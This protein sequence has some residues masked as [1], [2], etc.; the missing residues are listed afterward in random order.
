MVRGRQHPL[1]DFIAYY[2]PLFFVW[3]TYIAWEIRS[4]ILIITTSRLH[5][6]SE[7][8]M[9]R[10]LYVLICWGI[11]ALWI[12]CAF[13][14]IRSLR[15]KKVTGGRGYSSDSKAYNR[16]YSWLVNFFSSADPHKL[17]TSK[18]PKG[19]KWQDV[20][21][22]VMGKTKDNRLVFIPSDCE[23]NLCT[24]GAPGSGKTRGHAIVNAITFA[25]SV[26]AVD[27]K[28]D[29][30][31]YV[32][33]HSFRRI[34]R[35]CPDA[36]DALTESVHFDPLAGY[37]D[38]SPTD[39]KIFMANM[40]IIIIPDE[41]GE[42]G[43]YFTGRARKMLRAISTYMLW[44]APDTGFSDIVH[45]ILQGNIFDWA[46]EISK[47]DCLPAKELI[48]S[49]MDGNEKNAG[50]AYDTLTSALDWYSND[51]LDVLLSNKHGKCISVADLE[52]GND[53]YLQIDQDHLSVYGPLFTLIIQSLM[54]Q[55]MKRSD[56][57]TGIKKLPILFLLDEFP[58]LSL[59][60][61]M[62]NTA[63][64]TLRSKGVVI[65]MLMQDRSQ[66]EMK[67]TKEGARA[68]IA[69]C[70]YQLFLSSNDSDSS[71]AYSELFGTKKV[72][73]QS[74]NVTQ[75]GNTNGSTGM[76]I[77]I[78]DEEIY[79]PQIFNDLPATASMIVYC[80]GKHAMLQKLTAV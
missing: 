31:N 33:T 47:S 11:M 44:R 66:L 41:G 58:Q 67:Y 53:I 2:N 77:T 7:S 78:E 61:D 55:F 52:A 72:L 9:Y 64:S 76:T 65:D 22:I 50:G 69:C 40:S 62:A 70:N 28:G 46:E 42:S 26:L 51:V 1:R 68:L 60:Y 19:I 15:Y 49:L 16:S 37:N 63:L 14:R 27:I 71:K 35:F 23:S 74:N 20:K 32:S 30:Y 38:M 43:A 18:A 17:D 4:P 12:Y 75:N 10:L 48:L 13:C 59:T 21:G 54:I 57:S 36:P 8:M 45:A 6:P 29:I 24:F 80:K 5:I 79:P 3:G 56:T 39:R 73:K 34:Y 25:G